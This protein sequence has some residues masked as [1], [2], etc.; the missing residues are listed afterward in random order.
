MTKRKGLGNL[1]NSQLE[2]VI[3]EEKRLLILAGAGSGKTKT[4]LQKIIYLIEEKGVNSSDILAIT[5]TKNA[6]NE[7][8]DRL[9]ISTNQTKEYQTTLP[10]KYLKNNEKE[11]KRSEYRKRNRWVDALT[12]KTFHSFCYS[13]LRDYGVQEFDNRFKIIVDEKKNDEEEYLANMA[14]ERIFEVFQKLL[15][16]QCE[17][18]EYLL[19]LK[20]YVLDYLVD[21]IHIKQG[22]EGAFPKDGKFY[23]A[24]DGTKVRSKSE[25]YIAD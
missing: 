23:T 21:K 22:E 18:S 24:L 1:N 12:I 20:R 8:I 3:S 2:A 16:L 14:T 4:L 19:V 5:F 13:V 15:I 7:M 10:T 11:A 25:Q 9:I 6:A 17:S